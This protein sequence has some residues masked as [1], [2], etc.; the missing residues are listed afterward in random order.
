[1]LKGC[2]LIPQ[3]LDQA[4]TESLPIKE[5]IFA[6][7]AESLPLQTILATNTSSISVTKIAAAAVAPAQPAQATGDLPKGPERVVGLHFFNPVPVM[8]LVELIPALQ[9]SDTV[10]ARAKAF[11]EACGKTVTVSQDVPGFVSNRLLMPF[12]NEAVI[13]LESG[14]SSKEDIDT[15]LKLGMAHPMGPLQLADFIGLDTCLYIMQTLYA[16][17]AD[18]KYRPSV[19]LGRMVNAGWLGKKS[20]K[21][22]VSPVVAIPKSNK[23]RRRDFMTTEE[24]WLPYLQP[25]KQSECSIYRLASV[26][27][28]VKTRV[29]PSKR[30][31]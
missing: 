26:L 31:R 11:A 23:F 3:R 4:A 12:I 25:S 29:C 15:C 28:S 7:L 18:S 19:L 22:R 16:E 20:G 8:K 14:V 21:V 24:A 10:L 9:T 30:R 13:T 27:N 17:T 6:A 5:K 1:M 2:L